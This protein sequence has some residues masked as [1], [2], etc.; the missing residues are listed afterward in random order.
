MANPEPTRPKL[1]SFEALVVFFSLFVLALSLLVV[2]IRLLQQ[3]V[4][5]MHPSALL[6]LSIAGM[7]GSLA[8]MLVSARGRSQ[9][10]PPPPVE[11]SPPPAAAPEAGEVQEPNVAKVR[12]GKYM[13]T[14]EEQ[15]QSLRKERDTYAKGNAQFREEITEWRQRSLE[16]LRF[17]DKQRQSAAPEDQGQLEAILSAKKHF[18]QLVAP[19]G[20]G[21][22]EPEPGDRFDGKL[23]QADN[24]EEP[25]TAELIIVECLECGYTLN[26]QVQIPAK[27]TVAAAE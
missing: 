16:M 18:A 26:G 14:L 3:P 1:F 19:L 10:L 11:V 21:L 9:E 17:L 2:S 13:Q 6:V 15:V 8:G 22:I 4:E 25:P 23:H 20:I 27:V 7:I 24:L 12:L 5:G